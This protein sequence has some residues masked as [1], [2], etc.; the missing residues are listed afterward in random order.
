MYNDL[1]SIKII[2]WTNQSESESVHY[3]VK[4]TVGTCCLHRNVWSSDF[5]SAR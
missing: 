3:I 4:G 5:W 1:L 2:D